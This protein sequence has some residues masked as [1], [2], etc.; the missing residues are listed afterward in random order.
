MR[1]LGEWICPRS[2]RFTFRPVRIT[3]SGVVTTTSIY[4]VQT[5]TANCY[6]CFDAG[7]RPYWLRDWQAG[8]GGYT[9]V[10]EYQVDGATRR[11][12]SVAHVV[13][14]RTN[15]TNACL[16]FTLMSKLPEHKPWKRAAGEKDPSRGVILES[17]ISKRSVD[18]KMPATVMLHTN[19]IALFS[20]PSPSQT[21]PPVI[22]SDFLLILLSCFA[23][24]SF[25]M[26]KVNAIV[27]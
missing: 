12:F 27:V 11:R 24:L 21:H 9:K 4:G 20:A 7:V 5:K 22:S 2:T 18:W 23:F 13:R 8:F 26:N 1:F 10:Y 19:E 6:R 25:A 3:N 15:S 14:P 16:R 17:W